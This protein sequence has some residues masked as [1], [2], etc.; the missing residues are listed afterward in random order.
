VVVGVWVGYDQPAPIGEEAYGARIALPI[1]TDFMRRTE[2]LLPAQ[3]FE[4]PPGLREVEFCRMSYRRA[5][6]ECPTYTEYFKDGDDVP[7]ER[8]PIHEGDIKEQLERAFGRLVEDLGKRLRR[9][10]K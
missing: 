1:W 3:D 5:V 8:C 7:R 10:L 2:R 6:S 4:D 9:I